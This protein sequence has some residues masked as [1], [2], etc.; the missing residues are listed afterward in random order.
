MSN[1]FPNFGKPHAPLALAVPQCDHDRSSGSKPRDQDVHHAG[2]FDAYQTVMTLPDG[3]LGQPQ[4]TRSEAVDVPIGR[5]CHP[6]A[7][8]FL[9]YITPRK[10]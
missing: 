7:L 10:W 3:L 8:I 4:Q 5:T 9:L 6:G 2:R 1:L